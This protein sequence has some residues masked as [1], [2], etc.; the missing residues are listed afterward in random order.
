MTRQHT[1]YKQYNKSKQNKNNIN[2]SSNVN[3][4]VRL[5]YDKKT[6]LKIPKPARVLSNEKQFSNCTVKFNT[7]L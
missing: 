7:I 1:K 5:S 4:Y 2:M 3:R 6:D